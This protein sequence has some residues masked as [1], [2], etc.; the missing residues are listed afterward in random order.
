MLHLPQPLEALVP[1]GITQPCDLEGMIAFGEAVGVVVN[2]LPGR[3]ESR[4][5]V[6]SSLR[7]K[8]ASDSLHCKAIRTAIW[9]SVLR[10]DE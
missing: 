8:W 5:A 7:I 4:A 9:P 3:V 1:L 6:F 2:G 10:G